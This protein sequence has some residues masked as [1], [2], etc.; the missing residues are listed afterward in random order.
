[1]LTIQSTCV[2]DMFDIT[3]LN[4]WTYICYTY[5]LSTKIV[6]KMKKILSNMFLL[7]RGKGTSWE[8]GLQIFLQLNDVTLSEIFKAGTK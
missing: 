4:I 6:E 7:H 5:S 1:M 3:L 2:L 8:E